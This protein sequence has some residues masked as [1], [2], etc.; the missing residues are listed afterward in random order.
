M[1]QL[2]KRKGL[3]FQELFKGAN[4]QAIDLLEKML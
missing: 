3:D 1:S 2:P 4:L